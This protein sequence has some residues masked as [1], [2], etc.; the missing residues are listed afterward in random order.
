MI[1]EF[2]IAVI[3]FP[4]QMYPW[5]VQFVEELMEVLN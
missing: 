4:N 1:W 3:F 2:P 5:S